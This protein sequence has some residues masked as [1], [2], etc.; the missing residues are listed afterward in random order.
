MCRDNRSPF[1]P[2]L[3]GDTTTLR[4][5]SPMVRGQATYQTLRGLA[6]LSLRGASVGRQLMKD[7]CYWLTPLLLCSASDL[8]NVNVGG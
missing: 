8:A 4:Q 5:P 2:V 3:D 7:G 6:V 1:L